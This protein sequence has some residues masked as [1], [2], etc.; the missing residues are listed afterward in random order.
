MWT[1]P[2]HEFP[3][4]HGD[5]SRYDHPG[6]SADVENS[7]WTPY[8]ICF[9][10]FFRYRTNMNKYRIVGFQLEFRYME[11]CFY[12]FK[13]INLGVESWYLR[14][15]T[16]RVDELVEFPKY[17]RRC[18][19]PLTFIA[20]VIYIH[21]YMSDSIELPRFGIHCEC[22]NYIKMWIGRDCEAEVGIYWHLRWMISK[23]E[24]QAW[25]MNVW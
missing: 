19:L 1:W 18:P 13:S 7:D 21:R 5:R 9:C 16:P 2:P 4:L 15:C 23:Q 12:H 20:D 24:G 6:R 8:F 3:R 22:I 10:Y 14:F 25:Q 11:I 17:Q